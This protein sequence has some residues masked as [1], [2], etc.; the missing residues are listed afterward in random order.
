MQKQVNKQEGRELPL[1]PEWGKFRRENLPP[2]VKAVFDRISEVWDIPVEELTPVREPM[3]PHLTAS[4]YHPDTHSIE[5]DDTKSLVE[6]ELSHSADTLINQDMEVSELGDM[7]TRWGDLKDRLTKRTFTE[8]RAESLVSNRKSIPWKE[9][10]TGANFEELLAQSLLLGTSVGVSLPTGNPVLAGV[11]V[12]IVAASHVTAEKRM[13]SVSE[14]YEGHGPDGF[15][16]LSVDNP[17]RLFQF[18]LKRDEKRYLREGILYPADDP[19]HT[20]LTPKGLEYVRQ[21][22]PRREVLHRLK[23]M[24]ENR[25]K[26]E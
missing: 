20:G 13:K 23:A 12:S 24:K 10:S 14:F 25:E 26:L 15:I 9:K 6:H 3:K 4:V 19:G 5:T 16:L 21:K 22:T 7:K 11:G 2:K 17:H 1:P 18:S 8:G